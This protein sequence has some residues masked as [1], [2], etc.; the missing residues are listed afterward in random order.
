MTKKTRWIIFLLC[1]AVFLIIA[2]YIILYSLGYRVDFSNMRLVGT[3][4]IYVRATPNVEEIIIDD[5]ITNKPGIFSNAVFVQ[6]LLPTLHSV[7]IKKTGYHSYQK[8]LLVKE[9]EVTKLEHVILFKENITFEALPPASQSPFDRP[10]PEDRYVIKNN[11]L[12]YSN[13]PEN[14]DLTQTQKNT[15]VLENIIAYKISNGDIVWLGV[16]G[17]LYN[18]NANGQSVQKLSLLAKLVNKKNTY[19]I[20]TVGTNV[21]LKENAALLAFDNVTK[22]FQ[23]FYSPVIGMKESPNKEKFVFYSGSEIFYSFL[24]VEKPQKTSLYKSSEKIAYV[25]WINNDYI[26]FKA[27]DKIIISEI[28]IDNNQTNSITLAPITSPYGNEVDMKTAQV[29]FNQPDKKLYILNEADVLI[30]ERLIP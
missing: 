27:G 9:K 3:G 26:L 7:L 19:E 23:D 22:S 20:F 1:I 10:A 25:E 17:F 8:N 11:N 30:S 6:N 16:D 4:G 13:A 28:D 15:P 18:F 5:K 29:L 24:D 2:P 21:F 14:T 12:Y